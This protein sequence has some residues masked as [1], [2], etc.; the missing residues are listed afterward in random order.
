MCFLERDN[1][2]KVHKILIDRGKNNIIIAKPN[3]KDFRELF[4]ILRELK[5][6]N[7]VDRVFLCGPYASL[8][9]ESLMKIESWIDGI[10]LG[11]PEKTVLELVNAFLD[12]G[13]NCD[14]K[15]LGGIWRNSRN[16]IVI[17]SVSIISPLSLNE[18]PFPARDIEKIEN[19]NYI[20]LEASRGCIFNCSF[21]HIP[22][23]SGFSGKGGKIDA[24]DPKLVVN[25]IECLN[26]KLG[27]TLFI[28]NDDCFWR[29][30]NDDERIL[31]FCTE[32]RE[33]R[34]DIRFYIYLRC[35][36]FIGEPIIK[37]LSEVGLVRVFLGIENVS[38]KSQKVFNKPIRHY[39]YE[40]IKRILDRHGINVHIGY[41]AIE[42]YTTLDGVMLNIDYLY[43]INKLFR[44]GV[45]VEPVRVVPG[46]KLYYKLIQDGLMAPNLKYHEITYGYRFAHPE[47]KKILSGFQ[48]MF[49]NY[50]HS[51]SYKFEYYCTTGELLKV[52]AERL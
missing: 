49:L 14:I 24:R 40:R 52:L 30:H 9:A 19:G 42:P 20:N 7:M 13:L 17:K 36:P 51:W 23:I 27:K 39:T 5:K 4:S 22:L 47:V 15:C 41:I 33:R 50:L 31:E 12:N 2:H 48:K 34:L 21:C 3:F 6:Q 8:N 37:K 44:L 16:G 18:L 32:L 28:F 46:T 11:E 43:R 25:E 45:I 38:L 29:S 1:L 35:N 10:I 26:K